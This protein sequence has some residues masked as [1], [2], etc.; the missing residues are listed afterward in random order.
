[1][2]YVFL[3][4]IFLS[5]VISVG[6]AAILF[7]NGRSLAALLYLIGIMIIEI[8]FGTRWFKPD[9]N[10]TATVVVWPPAINVCPDF[11]SLYT[12]P[13]TGTAYCVDTVGITTSL[14]KWTSGSS[15]GT[16][17]VFNLFLDTAGSDRTSKLC[18]QATTM[19]LTWEGVFDGTTCLGGQ[20]PVPK[21][22][23]PAEKAAAKA[24]ADAAAAA[25]ACKVDPA[26]A[27]AAGAAAGAKA[28]ATAGAA[29]AAAAA[30]TTAT[31]T[32]AQRMAAALADDAR[33]VANAIGGE[34][35]VSNRGCPSAYTYDAQTKDCVD[36]AG[37]RMNPECPLGYTYNRTTTKCDYSGS[38]GYG[39]FSFS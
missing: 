38:S 17:N 10:T 39:I 12:D 5:F 21:L 20:P 25:A 1:M 23:S 15:V 24:T 22:P 3:F 4:Y 2:T 8:Y 34:Q 18:A 33:A 11:L 28:G 31:L 7:S 6:G 26:A 37:Q 19:G 32:P 14:T 35:A 30:A 36:V 13:L 16:N 27:S 29:A 9:G